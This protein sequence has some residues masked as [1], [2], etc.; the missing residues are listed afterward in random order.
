MSVN[1]KATLNKCIVISVSHVLTRNEHLDMKTLFYCQTAN[2]NLRYLG[3]LSLAALATQKLTE[4]D[5]V[6]TIRKLTR[7]TL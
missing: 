7:V 2:K 4:A 3:V 5:A 6:C 1:C